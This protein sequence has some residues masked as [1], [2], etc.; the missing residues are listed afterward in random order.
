MNN[1]LGFYIL[2][3]PYFLHKFYLLITNNQSPATRFLQFIILNH[4]CPVKIKIQKKYSIIRM[5]GCF[6]VSVEKQ[7]PLLLKRIKIQSSEMNWQY[8]ANRLTGKNLS[9]IL[10]LKTKLH[11]KTTLRGGSAC[12]C[13]NGFVQAGTIS[14]GAHRGL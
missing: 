7:P 6:L 5:K 4:C 8:K 10:S 11:L 9:V 12:L 13:R 3:K 2:Y 14:A 1:N